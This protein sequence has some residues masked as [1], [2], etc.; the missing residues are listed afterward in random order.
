MDSEMMQLG[1]I[2]LD[3]G[4]G[5][6]DIALFGEGA[7]KYT[8]VV[9]YGGDSLTND[10]FRGLGVSPEMAE[11][12]KRKYGCAVPDNVGEDEMIEVPSVMG[13]QAKP[14]PKRFVSEIISA[15][16]E[17]IFSIAK[18]KID[19]APHNTPVYGGVVLT[20]GAALLPDID[21]LARQVFDL[22]CQVRFPQGLRGLS[23]VLES[24]IYSTAVGLVE[25]G[26]HKPEGTFTGKKNGNQF[27]WLKRIF[28]NFFS[29]Y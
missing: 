15:R 25:Y 3:I 21:E 29:W 27:Q 2:L 18:D 20:G 1:S 9:P 19:N 6:T 22:P 26:F 5:T 11:N 4:G 16:M 13:Q 7:I 14:V 24:P 23:G 12:I 28:E 17:E 8:G 10:L